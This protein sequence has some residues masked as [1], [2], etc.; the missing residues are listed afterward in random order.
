MIGGYNVRIEGDTDT[1]HLFEDPDPLGQ[2]VTQDENPVGYSFD[3]IQA[4]ESE[5]RDQLAYFAGEPYKDRMEY[6][7]T[8]RATVAAVFPLYKY[9]HSGV[10][11][12]ITS[13]GDRWDSGQIGYVVVTWSKLREFGHNWKRVSKRR[14]HQLAEWVA[15]ELRYY[16]DLCMGNVHGYIIEK[17]GEEVGSCWGFVG[18][19]DRSG[20]FEAIQDEID[21]LRFGGAG[22]VGETHANRSIPAAG[23]A[24]DAAI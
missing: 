3:E 1:Y 16:T 5:D 21:G 9:E 7:E 6:R 18:D 22:A 2:R 8:Y 19:H 11:Y 17:D 12:S 10:A 23:S 20:I 13:F 14:R 24:G 15:D 4:V